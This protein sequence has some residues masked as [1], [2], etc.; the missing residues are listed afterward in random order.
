MFFMNQSNYEMHQTP[1]KK[2]SFCFLFYNTFFN[3]TIY[4]VCLSSALKTTPYAP[5]PLNSNN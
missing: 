5:L 4:L 3:A 1:K 2:I